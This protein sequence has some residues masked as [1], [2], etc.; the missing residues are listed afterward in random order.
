MTESPLERNVFF[1]FDKGEFD[2]R[3]FIKVHFCTTFG[4]ILYD[5][6]YATK[7]NGIYARTMEYINGDTTIK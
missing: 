3:D 2:K 5:L 7:W 6:I 4:H 1:Q